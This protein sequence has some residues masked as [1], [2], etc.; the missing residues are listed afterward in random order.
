MLRTDSVPFSGL[1]ASTQYPIALSILTYLRNTNLPTYGF[2][3][4]FFKSF[5]CRYKKSHVFRIRR[6]LKPTTNT[7][8]EFLKPQNE[9][10]YI[11]LTRGKT[12]QL[13]L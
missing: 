5:F 12:C 8:S 9:F 3:N 13:A 1:T 6:Q 11:K 10:Y 4:T 7:K 2:P